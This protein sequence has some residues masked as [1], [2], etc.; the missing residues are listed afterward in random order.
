MGLARSNSEI[1]TKI[2]YI[3]GYKRMKKKLLEILGAWSRA[4]SPDAA[5]RNRGRIFSIKGCLCF[6][7]LPMRLQGSQPIIFFACAY[8]LAVYSETKEKSPEHVQR[9]KGATGTAASI[10]T[11]TGYWPGHARQLCTP[12]NY[13]QQMLSFL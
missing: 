13:S 7:F 1:N 5:A 2:L 6:T 12:H 9:H 3:L 11:H 4:P 8:S 10:Q